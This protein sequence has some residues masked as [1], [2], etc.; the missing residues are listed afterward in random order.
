M[1]DYESGEL[2]FYPDWEPDWKSQTERARLRYEIHSYE[3]L[4]AE[5]TAN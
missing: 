5:L 1:R 3:L 4:R 2:R